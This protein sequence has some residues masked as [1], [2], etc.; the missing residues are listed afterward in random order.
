[1]DARGVGLC[2]PPSLARRF[3]GE[4][5]ARLFMLKPLRT[6]T[7][8]EALGGG[9]CSSIAFP[10]HGVSIVSLGS[11]LWSGSRAGFHAGYVGG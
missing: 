1:M 3:V 9:R 2:I 8:Y 4:G 11:P 7:G 10:S 5:D 6:P